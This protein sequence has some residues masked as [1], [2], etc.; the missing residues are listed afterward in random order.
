ME[1]TITKYFNTL[2]SLMS[3][4]F[5]FMVVVCMVLA[6]IMVCFSWLTYMTYGAPLLPAATIVA[7]IVHRRA[8]RDHNDEQ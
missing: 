5:F 1:K 6:V 8:Q 2:D 4:N 3:E 7:Y